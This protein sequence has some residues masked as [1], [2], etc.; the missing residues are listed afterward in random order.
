MEKRAV[1][2]YTIFILCF[3]IVLVRMIDINKSDYTE[4]I[5]KQSTRT[6][7]VG[8][9]RGEIFDRNFQPLVN[10][11]K[12]LLSVIT[13]CIQSYQYLQGA[14]LSEDITEKIENGYPFMVESDSE[15]N[16]E[17]IRTFSVPKRYSDDSL[18]CHIIGYLNYEGDT[19]VS[20]IE[21]AYN[22][23]LSKNSGTLKV[24]FEVDAL[25]RVM[26]GMKKTVSDNNFSSKAG[27]VLTIDKKFQQIAENALKN[28]KIKSGCAV[29]MHIDTGEIL[30]LASVPVFDPNNLGKALNEEN[31]PFVNK[32]LQS[33]SAGSV[34]KAVICAAAI[35]NGYNTE[36]E[37][38]CTG[39]ITVGDTA[40]H[41]YDNKSH[42]KVNMK[43]A[44]GYSCNTYF[45]NLISQ[46][47]TDYLLSLCRKLHLAESD[48]L[49]ASVK[50]ASGALPDENDL[51]K[52]GEL[53]N[54][55]FG[56]GK[57]LVTPIQM[58]K[59]YHTIATG[60]YVEPSLVMGLT[61][62]LGLMTALE[63]KTP[64]KILSD[65]TVA[66]MRELLSDV[67]ENG[68][69]TKAKSTLLSLAGKT[70]T[71]ESG[72]YKDGKQLLRTW[73]AGFFPSQN[74]HYIVV[75]LNEN[76][77]SGNGDCGGVFKEICEKMVGY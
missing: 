50:T 53:S 18:A 60:N 36:T 20:G 6:L 14:K 1:I 25:G 77:E 27:V 75:V 4:V 24:S 73:F 28:S 15:I 19:G 59:I 46:I 74:P 56:Q 49:C 37:Y 12:R 40:Y 38:E 31:S 68:N 22:E 64:T 52:K 62:Q 26:A 48:T 8:E 21:K 42:G 44:L 34:F 66:T 13:P 5:E 65:E 16:N 29:V 30:A 2:I 9:K 43:T 70:G 57:L 69:A 55:A 10:S 32:A 45:I 33:Y 47:D 51:K 17:L 71:A 41:C 23:Y 67:V 58:L 35:E 7:T 61:N 11:E 63:K 54:F 76:G 3:M 39:E 72:I